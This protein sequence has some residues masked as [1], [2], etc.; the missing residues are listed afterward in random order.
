MPISTRQMEI[1]SAGSTARMPLF[2]PRSTRRRALSGAV[3]LLTISLG[4][5]LGCT[6]TVDHRFTFDRDKSTSP[7][8]AATQPASETDAEASRRVI[9]EMLEDRLSD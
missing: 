3:L 8:V 4:L 1:A 2:A 6:L 7:E 5:T 9:R